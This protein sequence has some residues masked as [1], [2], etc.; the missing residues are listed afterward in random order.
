MVHG[1][2]ET[3]EK[4]GWQNV[5]GKDELQQVIFACGVREDV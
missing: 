5:V 1:P 3:K 2:G 4:I